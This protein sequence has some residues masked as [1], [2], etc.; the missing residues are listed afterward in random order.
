M[1][2]QLSLLMVLLPIFLF[3]ISSDAHASE[4]ETYLSSQD[5]SAS[6]CKA[7]SVLMPNLSF[8]ILMTCRNLIYPGN[9]N[10]F[11]LI[12]WAEPSDGGN[13]I[14]LGELGVGKVQFD[15]N[16]AFSRIFVTREGS[17]RPRNPGTNV[18]MS[19][20]VEPIPFRN[21]SQPQARPTSESVQ[22]PT[23]TPA[24]AQTGNF[25]SRLFS[26]GRIVAFLGV[27]LLLVLVFVL[28]RR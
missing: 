15:T 18:V 19:G 8:E 4:G 9:A 24:T 7:Y 12:A 20:S 2:K 6:E 25:F 10:Q 21:G 13:P 23:P 5:G 17:S 27:I 3:I 28:T 22:T 11:N 16:E 26:P 1:K 14:R